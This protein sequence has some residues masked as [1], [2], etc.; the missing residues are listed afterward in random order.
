MI[1]Q[2]SYWVYIW[3]QLDFKKI[4][5]LQCFHGR[6]CAEKGWNIVITQHVS[7]KD[8]L[9]QLDTGE[10]FLVVHLVGAAVLGGLTAGAWAP[11]WSHWP[12]C[13]SCWGQSHE[14]PRS[15]E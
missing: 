9:G 2:S 8:T 3:R 10:H 15:S 13:T 5:T 7:L 11:P 14:T 6:A 4:Y 1:H 12:D